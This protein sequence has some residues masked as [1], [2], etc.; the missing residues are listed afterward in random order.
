MAMLQQ[1]FIARAKKGQ[2]QK[3]K[4]GQQKKIMLR[5]QRK[6]NQ[7]NYKEDQ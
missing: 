3:K 5:R 4:C 1:K 6:Q 2:I 7:Q